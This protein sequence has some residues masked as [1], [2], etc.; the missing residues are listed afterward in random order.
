MKEKLEYE[1]RCRAIRLLEQGVRSKQVLYEVQRGRFLL[2]KWVRSYKVF[3][4]DGL[5]D[6]GRV[7]KHVR[8][9]TREPLIHKI[10]ALRDELAAHKTRCRLPS[11]A[12]PPRC[13]FLLFG[14]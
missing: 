9:R 2:A 8:N 5:R 4:L 14:G 11:A 6:Q 12:N 1:Q 3:G 10:L 7:P 13:L